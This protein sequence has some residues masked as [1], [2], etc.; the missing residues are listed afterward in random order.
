MAEPKA[1]SLVATMA[2][3]KADEMVGVT[4]ET[5]AAVKVV[6]TVADLVGP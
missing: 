2:D 6:P 1:S 5:T 4:A 3:L